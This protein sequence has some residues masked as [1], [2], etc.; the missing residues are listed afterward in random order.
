[1]TQG[2]LKGKKY[3]YLSGQK[4]TLKKKYLHKLR[5]DIPSETSFIL[6]SH[7]VQGHCGKGGRKNKGVGDM[8][9]ALHLGPPSTYGYLI[10]IRSVNILA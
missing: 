2:L 4:P 9:W 7:K 8:M 6:P 1:M 5:V 10:R 3:M